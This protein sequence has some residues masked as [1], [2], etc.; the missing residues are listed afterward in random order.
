MKKY[1]FLFY[2]LGGD[3][4]SIAMRIKEEGHNIFIYKQKDQIKGRQDTGEGIFDKTEIVVDAWKVINSTSKDDLIILVDDN[5]DGHTFDHLRADGYKVVGGSSFAEEIEHERGKGTKLMEKIGLSTPEE[6][7]F[8]KFDDAIDFLLDQ[9]DEVRYVFK[10]DGSD[11]AGS[12]K[13]YTGK[14]KQDLI[15]YLKWIKADQQVKHYDLTKFMLQEFV[16]GYEADIEV[17]F[18]GE[19]FMDFVLLDIEEKKTGDGNLGEACGCMGNVVI[20]LKKSRY[21]DEYL[22]KIAPLLKKVNYVGSISINNIFAQDNF[23]ENYEDG[24]PQGIEWT[25]RCGWDAEITKCAIIK[26]A[27]LDIADYYIAIAEKKPFA[28]PTNIA[29]CGVR[30][31][32]G[33][34]TM[35]K[36]EVSGRYFS[37]DKDIEENLYF[38]S[39]SKSEKGYCIEDNPVLVVNAVDKNF[40]NAIDG[41]YAI[42]KELNIPDMYYRKEIGQRTLEVVKFLRAYD[43]I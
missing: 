10:P 12:S 20:A 1:T 16:N 36:E 27:G 9:E 37:F 18:D 42:L 21:F 3:F 33:S 25:S 19:K 39:V 14:N 30:V 35:K 41:A 11:L 28:F 5:G 22:S 13:T 17:V 8:D 4:Q 23:N 43:W 2:Q 15:D 6:Y 32:T 38:Y 40:Q 29:G 26:A 7:S 31:Y 24:Q 34:A